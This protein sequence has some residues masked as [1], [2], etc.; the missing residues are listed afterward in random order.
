MRSGTSTLVAFAVLAYLPA[1]HAGPVAISTD[2]TWFDFAVGDVGDVWR[3]PLDGNP[4]MFTLTSA[5]A[6]T[7]RLVD[8]GFAGDR[9]EVLSGGTTALGT[10]SDVPTDDSVFAFTPDEAFAVPATWS[11][12]TW[13]L[14]AGTYSFTGSATAS[15]FGGGAWAISAL[16]DTTPTIP[17]PGSWGLVLSALAL[18]A[19]STR[20]RR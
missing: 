14:G 5:S 7:L 6:F 17:E 11:Q 3:S 2:G 20:R 12:G 9:V 4:I 8:V 19:A 18:A 13:L 10:T 1:P 16:A 15:P